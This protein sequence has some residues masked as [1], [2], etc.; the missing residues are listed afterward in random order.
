MAA[1]VVQQSRKRPRPSPAE[2]RHEQVVREEAILAAL[3]ALA[4]RLCEQRHAYE[5]CMACTETMG[6]AIARDSLAACFECEC[7]RQWAAAQRRA[8]RERHAD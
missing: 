4:E 1:F 3:L 5:R 6:I 8:K 2:A 7:V